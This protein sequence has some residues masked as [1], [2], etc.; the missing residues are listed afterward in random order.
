VEIGDP[1]TYGAVLLASEF[2]YG[3]VRDLTLDFSR[4]GCAISGAMLGKAYADLA[5]T[6][7]AA[8]ALASVPV[9]PTEVDVYM[10]TTLGGIGGTKL[11]RCLSASLK[12]TSRFG[13]FW[14]LNSAIS[15]FA[16]HVETPPDFAV[17]LKV[18]ADAVGMGPLALL[19]LG[20]TR[21]F[22][23]K[24]TSATVAG[25]TLPYDLT[26]DFAGKFSAISDFSDEDGVYALEYTVACT[27]ELTTSYP[28]LVTLHNKVADVV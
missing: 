26:L 8:T 1:G 6:M 28:L 7:T 14:T 20:S 2:S 15:G 16:V 10:D 19:R 25:A 13:P 12:L 24:A 4:T 5:A 21:W 3:L 23:I 17:A 11:T 9:Q 27:P 22:R 18:E